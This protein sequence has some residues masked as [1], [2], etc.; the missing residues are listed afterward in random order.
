MEAGKNYTFY[1]YHRSLVL[2]FALASS[3]AFGQLDSNSVTVT[4]TRSSN[5]QADQ[6]LFGIFVDTGF[7]SNLTDVVALLQGAGVTAANFSNVSTTQGILILDPGPNPSGDLQPRP[8]LEWTFGLPVPMARMKDTVSQLNA[9]Q[10]SIAKKGGAT[11]SFQ[12]QG[13]QVSPQLQQSQSCSISDLLTDARAQAQ[14]LADAAGLNLG[15]ILAL[16]SVAPNAVSSPAVVISRYSSSS[17]SYYSTPCSLTVK[18][19]VSRY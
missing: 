16:S 8:I 19:A 10:Q 14:K 6:M 9:L 3:L 15:V 7:D 18:F 13:T 4:A 11:M 17:G 12:V 5:P 2:A 1:M